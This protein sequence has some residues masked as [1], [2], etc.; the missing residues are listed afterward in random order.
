MTVVVGFV[1]PD[2]A[3]MCSDSQATE[4]GDDTRREVDKMWHEEEA[5]LLFG[6][7][8]YDAIKEPLAIAISAALGGHT[9]QAL[10]QWQVRDL[11]RQTAQPVL[12]N[13]Y[14]NFVGTRPEETAAMLKG[15][16]L[17]IGHDDDGYWLLEIDGNNIASF[18]TDRGFH[19]IGSGSLAAQVARGLLGHYEPGG[20]TVGHLKLLAYR[21]VETCIRVLGGRWGVGG[22]P[23]LCHSENGDQFSAASE[24]EIG[25]IEN[26]VGAWMLVEKESLD[27]AFPQT[28]ATEEAQAEVAAEEP[29]PAPPEEVKEQ[30]APADE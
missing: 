20:R 15:A 10:T 9:G 8:G 14:G 25:A 19:A 21:T 4:A 6:Y 27:Q 13:A 24:E 12:A 17:V 7:S 1:G 18:Y 30:P 26:S 22:S 11:L 23:R 2:G 29:P 3:V 28:A 5:G 16:L